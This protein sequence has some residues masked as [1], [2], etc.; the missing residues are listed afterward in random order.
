[1]RA[2][3]LALLLVP[4]LAAI[5]PAQS[6]GETTLE[7][8]VASQDR[9]VMAGRYDDAVKMA[10]RRVEAERD[11]AEAR[12]LLGRLFGNEGNRLSS[13]AR[14][15]AAGGD[16]EKALEVNRSALTLVDK[17]GVQFQGALEL[18]TY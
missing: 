5:A 14:R 1:M 3:L 17:A 15:M 8:R 12:Y 9:M 2:L 18:D 16:T 6:A 11:S 4:A 13:A 7:D 10:E